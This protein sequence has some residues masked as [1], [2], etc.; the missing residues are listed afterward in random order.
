MSKQ[1]EVLFY[2]NEE[3]TARLSHDGLQW[4]LERGST[5]SARP[6]KDSGFR[7]VSFVL[8]T[9][10]TLLRCIREKSVPVDINGRCMLAVLPETYRDCRDAVREQGI[11]PWQQAM[12][13]SASAADPLPDSA[14]INRAHLLRQESERKNLG[15]EHRIVSRERSSSASRDLK[16]R[17][18]RDVQR[19]K[20]PT[21]RRPALQA[22]PGTVPDGSCLRSR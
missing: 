1:S 2:L 16:H 13:R 11:E 18:F 3:Q 17:Q 20:K 22:E 10:G 4:I 21:P 12:A 9:K 14:I 5:R 7:G 19:R 15:A 8:N 6:K